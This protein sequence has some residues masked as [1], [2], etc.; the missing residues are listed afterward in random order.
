L[1]RPGAEFEVRPQV[2]AGRL[3][4]RLRVVVDP[5][6]PGGGLGQ[7]PA[8]VALAA[9]HIEH[10]LPGGELGRVQ[11]PVPVLAGEHAVVG[12]DPGVFDPGDES[13]SGELHVNLAWHWRS[14]RLAPPSAGPTR[15]RGPVCGEGPGAPARPAP[16]R[17]RT[18]PRPAPPGTPPGRPPRAGPWGRPASP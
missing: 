14:R 11:V 12:G 15:P 16:G 18:A 17:G 13:L 1:D 8:A 4:D 7:Q 3:P 10:R 9:G 2:A 6:H 5:E